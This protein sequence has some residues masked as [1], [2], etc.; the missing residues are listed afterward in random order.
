MGLIGRME[1]GTYLF[2]FS[3]GVIGSGDSAGWRWKRLVWRGERVHQLN[4]INQW[5]K[6]KRVTLSST[7][8]EIFPCIK[9]LPYTSV[10]TPSIYRRR[11][12]FVWWLQCRV[13]LDCSRMCGLGMVWFT[14][15]IHHHMGCRLFSLSQRS[16]RKTS[17]CLWVIGMN[18]DALGWMFVHRSPKELQFKEGNMKDS[19]LLALSVWRAAVTTMHTCWEH[20]SD[21]ESNVCCGWKIDLEGACML[22]GLRER[23]QKQIGVYTRLKLGTWM[24]NSLQKLSYY[25]NHGRFKRLPP[26]FWLCLFVMYSS[27]IHKHASAVCVCV[28]GCD[29]LNRCVLVFISEPPESQSPLCGE[30]ST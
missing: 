9:C 4:T 13:T 24:H 25:F 26:Y 29:W 8:S 16:N 2:P 27:V 11:K 12:T 5:Q 21:Q 14:T 19:P 20:R 7:D 15:L 18:N 10:L 23:K 30:F 17:S 3:H 6:P 28:W 1:T 22:V